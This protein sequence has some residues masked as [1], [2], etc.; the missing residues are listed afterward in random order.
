[1]HWH[2]DGNIITTVGQREVS[3]D[4][5]TINGEFWGDTYFR[6]K[7]YCGNARSIWVFCFNRPC[8]PLQAMDG[9]N[10]A[11]IEQSIE[12]LL[13]GIIEMKLDKDFWSAQE[14]VQIFKRAGFKDDMNPVFALI[15]EV[16]KRF[17]RTPNVLASFL[18]SESPV[19]MVLHKRMVYEST[20]KASMLFEF[21]SRE[22]LCRN[23]T[24]PTLCAIVQS[25]GIVRHEQT[26]L[27]GSTL[28]LILQAL[29]I[30][31]QLKQQL[32]LLSGGVCA[33]DEK[34]SYAMEKK[35]D[36]LLLHVLQKV[37]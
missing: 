2:W 16:P 30:I 36:R 22:Y 5:R 37:P 14:I 18:K 21:L 35:V 23:V 10:F 24:Y 28:P 27:D 25:F 29:S 31:E 7:L 34:L 9:L 33:V 17:S 11:S 3:T 20:G 4:V 6:H 32:P 13:D 8:T 15:R 26:V 1:M 12:T 19:S